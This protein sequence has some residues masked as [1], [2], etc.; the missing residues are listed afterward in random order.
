MKIR[1]ITCFWDPNQTGWDLN[2]PAEYARFRAEAAARFQSAGFEVQT[3]RLSTTDFPRYLDIQKGVKR[4]KSQV[5]DIEIQSREAGFDYLSFGSVD[6]MDGEEIYALIPELLAVSRFAFFS[7]K[8]ACRK[9]MYPLLARWCARIIRANR[10]IEPEGFA[11]LRFAALAQVRPGGP[12]FPSSYFKGGKPAFALAIE[13]ADEAVQAFSAASSLGDG[14]RLLINRL[15]SLARQMEQTA[16][17]LGQEFDFDFGGFDFSLAPFPQDSV[18][19]GAAM[20]LLGIPQLGQ[21]GSLAAAAFIADTLDLGQW[22]R[23]GFNGLMMPVLEDSRLAQRTAEGVLTVQDLL[24]YSAVCGTGLD[25]VPLPGD[26]SEDDLTGL[27]LDVAALATRLGK[28]LT[29]RLMPI[30]GKSAGDDTS[31]TF[32]YFANGRVLGIKPASVGG[33]LAAEEVI[34]LKPR[35]KRLEFKE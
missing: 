23:A 28:P 21:G 33:L 6:A 8:L 19:L 35:L 9:L 31:F 10:E 12:F 15:N 32:D 22:K 4:V 27:L 7:G 24:M 16:F 29:A 20:E 5:Q 26:V 30:P 13:C 25:T 2:M 14:R 18:S 3:T 1:S 17:S 34:D 11:N